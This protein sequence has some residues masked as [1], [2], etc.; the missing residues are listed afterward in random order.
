MVSGRAGGRPASPPVRR[1]RTEPLRARHADPL[2][3]VRPDLV[4][5]R[6]SADRVARGGVGPDRRHE[7]PAAAESRARRRAGR[8][9][10]R[11]RDD[12]GD[13]AAPRRAVAPLVRPLAA[14]G[15][16]GDRAERRDAPGAV[17]PPRRRPREGDGRRARHRRRRLL[18]GATVG[19]GSGARALL[20]PRSLHRIPRRARAEEEPRAPDPGVR[21]GRANRRVARDRRG[22]GALG[23]GVRGAGRR[24]GG[25]PVARGAGAR[26]SGRVRGSCRSSGAAVGGRDPRLP[27]ARRG[28]RVPDP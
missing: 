9:R 8:A 6:H 4:A 25:G 14:S 10:P 11:V 23:A 17:R 3:H 5:D 21:H 15:Q 16:R 26:R 20:D 27:V 19:G 12:A 7:L 28:V 1:R 13:R 24:R 22:R 18:A 2:A